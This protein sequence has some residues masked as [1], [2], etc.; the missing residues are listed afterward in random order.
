MTP[1]VAVRYE[2]QVRIIAGAYRSRRLVLPRGSTTRPTADR[3]REALFN[4]LGPPSA[5]VGEPCRVLDL[6]A[7]SGALALEALSRGADEAVLVEQ[8]AA[9]AAAAA[10]NVAAL[11]LAARVRIVD[12]EVGATLRRLG[13]RFHW[14][15]LDPPYGGGALDRALRLLGQSPLV[16]PSGL[17]IAEHAA[18]SPPAERYGRLVLSDLRRWGGTAVSFYRLEL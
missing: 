13:G 18:A 9:A 1:R 12:G 10:R 7:G 2:P 6:F 4:I 3:V 11:D 17:V 5:P 14:I 8:D 15:F 16:A